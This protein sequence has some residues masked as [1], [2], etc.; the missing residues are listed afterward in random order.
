MQEA[1]SPLSLDPPEPPIQVNKRDEVEVSQ[2][3]GEERFPT[4]QPLSRP[5]PRRQLRRQIAVSLAASFIGSLSAS[6]ATKE[7]AVVWLRPRRDSPPTF[8]RKA[9]A[10]PRQLSRGYI[11]G[12]ALRGLCSWW[13][14]PRMVAR[15]PSASANP[16]GIPWSGLLGASLLELPVFA[17]SGL[18]RCAVDTEGKAG[19][20]D[21]EVVFLLFYFVVFLVF[22]SLS[23]LQKVLFWDTIRMDQ[24][25]DARLF[26]TLQ[27]GSSARQSRQKNLAQPA[28]AFI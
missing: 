8:G 6:S 25:T 13:A 24:R 14:A 16:A 18:D 26:R 10:H 28:K 17:A 12:S 4:S 9:A 15:P 2:E 22:W 11:G 20:V 1:A 7:D 3:S 5:C 27:R 23:W 19:Q 21:Q